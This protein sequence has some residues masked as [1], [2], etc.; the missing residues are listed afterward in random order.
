MEMYIYAVCEKV[1]GDDRI[2]YIHPDKNFLLRNELKRD[3]KP[4][5]PIIFKLN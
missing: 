2:W 1:V 3:A 5:N 4:Y